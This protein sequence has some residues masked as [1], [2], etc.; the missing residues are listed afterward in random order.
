ME[1]D[2]LS[3]LPLGLGCLMLRSN[4]S[5]NSRDNFLHMGK[6]ARTRRFSP[7]I[8]YLRLFFTFHRQL[9]EKKKKKKMI[10]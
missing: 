7:E 9:Q 6:R 1:S 3:R 10:A 2:P 5:L 4:E 8:A